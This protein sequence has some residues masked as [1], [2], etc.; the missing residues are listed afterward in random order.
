[1]FI[2]VWFNLLEGVRVDQMV[3]SRQNGRGGGG[4]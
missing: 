1:M 3:R 2:S 4:G